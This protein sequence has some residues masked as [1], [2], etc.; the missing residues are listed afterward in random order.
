[1]KK[2]AKGMA[3]VGLL[4]MATGVE[5]GGTAIHTFTYTMPIISL[6]SVGSVSV[7]QFTVTPPVV[8]GQ[9]LFAAPTAGALPN[10]NITY[11]DTTTG[12]ITAQLDDGL[13]G[14][15][16]LNA[17]LATPTLRT[18]DATITPAQTAGTFTALPAQN[19]TEAVANVANN[20]AGVIG[21]DIQVNY[22]LVLDALQNPG[23]YN[24]QITLT[25]SP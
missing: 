23:V 20:I 13:P 8:A 11:N 19:I 12:A 15:T 4:S 14:L 7:A 6:F 9:R 24:R 18:A 16:T 25:L 22:A 3:L 2:I 10:Y 17:T 1:M 5:A 21:T